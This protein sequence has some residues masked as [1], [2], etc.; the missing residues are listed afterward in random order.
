[1]PLKVDFGSW[2]PCPF[3]EVPHCSQAQMHSFKKGY[4]SR[5]DL[6]KLRVV[7]C[8]W[9]VREFCIHVGGIIISV[10]Y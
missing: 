8:L 10:R 3:N 4:Q 1:M 2:E 5:T 9:F 7:I 6:V